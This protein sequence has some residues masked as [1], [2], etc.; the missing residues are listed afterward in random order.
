MRRYKH[1]YRKALIKEYIEHLPSLDE[2][3]NIKM[4]LL[5]HK[6]GEEMNQCLYDKTLV[7]EAPELSIRMYHQS[8]E[9]LKTLEELFSRYPNVINEGTKQKWKRDLLFTRKNKSISEVSNE[10]YFKT[11][12]FG[13]FTA[14]GKQQKTKFKIEQLQEE[15][16]EKDIRITKVEVELKEKDLKILKVEAELWDLRREVM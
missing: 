9:A 3:I 6:E 5:Q 14:N 16:K 12:I 10:I 1:K 4:E 2:Q 11:S 13:I 7:Q 8:W 15:L